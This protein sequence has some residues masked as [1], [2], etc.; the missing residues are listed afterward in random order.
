MSVCDI[1]TRSAAYRWV[2][3]W[4]QRG[5]QPSDDQTNTCT[6]DSQHAL[7]VL[8]IPYFANGVLMGTAMLRIHYEISGR[9]SLVPRPSCNMFAK[10]I[11][12][13]NT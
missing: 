12:A 13:S 1:C 2:A 11:C 3:T 9:K 5:V 8:G 4:T 7:V 6:D 10:G